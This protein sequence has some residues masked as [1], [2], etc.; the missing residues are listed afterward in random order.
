MV[1]GTWDDDGWNSKAAL[2]KY[3]DLN[4]LNEANYSTPKT[5]IGNI[6]E[7]RA[8]NSYNFYKN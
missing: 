6:S 1:T 4:F 8:N 3:R 2:K 7:K 5:V